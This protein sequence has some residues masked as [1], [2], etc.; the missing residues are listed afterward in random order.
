MNRNMLPH[1]LLLKQKRVHR[2]ATH[3]Y[4]LHMKWIMSMLPHRG[5]TANQSQ[6]VTQVAYPRSATLV[7][8]IAP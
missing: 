5:A 3:S 2:Q 4:Q 7:L 8:G 1:A 6:S